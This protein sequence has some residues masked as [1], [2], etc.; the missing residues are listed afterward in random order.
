MATTTETAPTSPTPT[1]SEAPA[2][3]DAAPA[4]SETSNKGSS[5]IQS[6]LTALSKAGVTEEAPHSEPEPDKQ[7]P[8][9]VQEEKAAETNTPTSVDSEEDDAKAE[10]DIKRETANMS[11]S[12]KAAFTKLRYEARD[13]KRQLKAAQAERE[14]IQSQ[15]PEKDATSQNEEIERIKSEYEALKT[16]VSEY[17]K[18]AYTTRLETTELYQNEIARPRQ[19]IAET[20]SDIAKRYPD[21][22]EEAVISAVRTADAERV[23]RVTAD[24]S[25][26]DRFRF[27]KQVEE[28][29]RLNSREGELRN[30]SKAELERIYREQR[31]KEESK[32]SEENGQWQKALKDTWE[33][34]TED[35]PVLAP[36]DNDDDWNAKLDGVKSFASPERYQSLTVRERAEALYRAAAFPVLVAELEAVMDDLKTTQAKLSKYDGASPSVSGDASGSVSDSESS[37]TIANGSFVESAMQALR[38]AGA[39]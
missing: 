32:K 1:P 15:T 12:H 14:K 13:L 19:Q 11:A 16:K 28:Y 7:P 24:M 37:G 9:A 26:F 33:Q 20:V 39:R 31:E 18:E 3:Q 25:E 21:I 30:N 4:S 27:Y 5:F 6:A 22:D 10:A 8:P 23:S 17:E 29:H 2:Q 34:L 35:F 38:K 36:V